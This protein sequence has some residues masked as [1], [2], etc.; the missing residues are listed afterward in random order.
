VAHW[1]NYFTHV[2]IGLATGER[3]K[4]DLDGALWNGV[5]SATRQNVLLGSGNS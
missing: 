4:I 1:N 3:Q 2:P 5:L